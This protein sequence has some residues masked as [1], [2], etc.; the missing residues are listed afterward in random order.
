M[1][2]ALLLLVAGSGSHAAPRISATWKR[3]SPL[4]IPA[5]NKE[6]VDIALQARSEGRSGEDGDIRD[7][8]RDRAD[9]PSK[10]DPIEQDL[11][12]YL[13]VRVRDGRLVTTRLRD[14]EIIGNVPFPAGGS[15]TRKGFAVWIADPNGDRSQKPLPVDA[16]TGKPI[17][18]GD[19]LIGRFGETGRLD[20][21][22]SYTVRYKPNG[23][24]YLLRR[25]NSDGTYREVAFGRNELGFEWFT[26][27][28]EGPMALYFTGIQIGTFEYHVVNSEL[29]TIP[30]SIGSIHDLSPRGLLIGQTAPEV[31][32]G[33]P[34]PTTFD[35]TLLDAETGRLRWTRKR[36]NGAVQWCGAYLCVVLDRGV[37]VLDPATG[38]AL[39][40]EPW[41][42][43]ALK[44]FGGGLYGR[45]DASG[46]HLDLFRLGI[47][48]TRESV[49]Q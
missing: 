19:S 6:I 34:Q 43:A 15:F 38:H 40:V 28:E 36:P 44:A 8:W 30:M 41:P 47:R 20:L 31:P 26:G 37:A 42:G 49:R 18:N 33:S 5:E 2:T 12:T 25:W 3:L 35:L 1:T 13:D 46:S 16:R 23:G 39:V 9:L 10:F 4:S 14:G 7:W 27:T 22:P 45:E 24:D 21:F 17:P 48:R 11:G 32:V 29:Q